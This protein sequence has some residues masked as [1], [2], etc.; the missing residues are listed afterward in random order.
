MAK[1]LALESRVYPTLGLTVNAGD[2]VE[3]PED[4]DVTGLSK[5]VDSKSGEKTVPVKESE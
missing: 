2:V 3:L 4:T 5:M 1:F